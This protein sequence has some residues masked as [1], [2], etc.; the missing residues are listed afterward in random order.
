[1]TVDL[2]Y[3]TKVQA[4]KQ[5]SK[6]DFIKIKNFCAS[7]N[8]IKKVKRQL[9]CYH[10]DESSWGAGSLAQWQSVY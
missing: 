2:I 8:I 1:M 3:K 6:L 5:N 10:M 7:N 4:T 9:T